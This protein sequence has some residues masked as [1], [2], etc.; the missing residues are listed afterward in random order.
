MRVG[1]RHAA[2]R[3]GPVH[4][5]GRRGDR[6]AS[7]VGPSDAGQRRDRRRRR[8]HARAR[9][10]ARV[11]RGHPAHR[12]GRTVHGRA[13]GQDHPVRRL[14]SG[15]KRAATRSGCARWCAGPSH[16]RWRTTSASATNG[17]SRSTPTSMGETSTREDETWMR[18]AIDAAAECP[19]S[20]RRA[21]RVRRGP[22]G[23]GASGE[24]GQRARATAGPHRARRGPRSASGGLSRR[25]LAPGR[26]TPCTSRWSRAPCARV[27]SCWRGCAGS[28]SGR[29]IRR[30][31]SRARWGTW[32]RTN[33]S[34]TAPRYLGVLADACGELLRAFFRDRR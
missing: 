31:G 26:I 13:A 15:A 5:A 6:L 7:R 33:G 30:P 34:T 3:P 8:A 19:A 9:E 11:V 16:T 32:S 25:F 22:R 20:G 28:S 29:R 12:P 2:A 10:P 21:G 14:R 27:R 23:R 4:G 24:R 1:Y 17:C 18:A